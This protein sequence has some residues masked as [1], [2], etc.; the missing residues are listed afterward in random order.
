MNLEVLPIEL[1]LNISEETKTSEMYYNCMQ[2]DSKFLDSE[3][4]EGFNDNKSKDLNISQINIKKKHI[5]S[6]IINDIS[7]DIEINDKSSISEKLL[8]NRDRNSPE[9]NK[10]VLLKLTNSNIDQETVLITKKFFK[11]E[12]NENKNTDPTLIEYKNLFNKL[13]DSNT[14]ILCFSDSYLLSANKEKIE[15]KTS[16]ESFYKKNI[17]LQSENSKSFLCRICLENESVL[18]NVSAIEK[19]FIS[20]CKCQ[21]TMKFVHEY[22]LKKWIPNSFKNNPF[23]QCEI[24]KSDYKIKIET[25]SVFSYVRMCAF[26]EKLLIFFGSLTIFTFI[27]EFIIYSI[28]ESIANFNFEEDRTFVS[29]LFIGGLAIILI[30]LMIIFIN[31][32]NIIYEVIPVKF[33]IF[34]HDYDINQVNK[35]FD[36]ETLKKLAI[37]LDNDF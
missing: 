16:N 22:C 18:D 6:K 20:P 34:N 19:K 32:R 23:P 37:D 26:L 24:C 30:V 36:Y 31:Y 35:N 1:E 8:L 4:L 7:L 9:I 29:F 5:S 10:N 12:S 13:D 11:L 15:N 25:K 28:V 33:K 21:G 3:T 2:Y 27:I 17:N 14:K